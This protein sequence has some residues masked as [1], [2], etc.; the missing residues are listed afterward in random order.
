MAATSPEDLIAALEALKALQESQQEEL[1]RLSAENIELRDAVQPSVQLAALT[2]E[3]VNAVNVFA[4]A[5]QDMSSGDRRVKSLIDIKGLG[6]P[7]TFKNDEQRFIEWLRKTTGFASAAYGASFRGVLEWAEDQEQAI[8]IEDL[9]VQFG[10]EGSEDYVDDIAEKDSQLH[11]ALQALTEG[12]S[13]DIVLGATPHGV[14][15]LRRLIRRWDPA[16]GG[17]RRVILRQIVQPERAK[18]TELP[19]ALEKWDGLLRRYQKR[20]AGG[21]V[22]QPVDDDIKISALEG[23][24]PSEL[25]QHLAMNR[26]RL[27][28]YAQVR[29]E[30]DAYVDAKHSQGAISRRS[31]KKNE[32]AMDVDSFQKG[33]KGKGK[34]KG[35]GKK[36]GAVAGRGNQTEAT[37][38]NCGKPG[39]RQADCWSQ[40]QQQQPAAAKGKGKKGG[41]NKGKPANSLEEGRAAQGQPAPEPSAAGCL[42]ICSFSVV[43]AAELMSLEERNVDENGWLRFTFDTGAAITAFPSDMDVGE[44]T[45]Q[46]DATYRTASGEVIEDRGGLAV[47]GWSESGH[48]VRLSGRRAD[49]HKVLV[50]AGQVH[51]RGHITIL[52]KGGGY[53]IP[54][55]SDLAKKI[56]RLVSNEI[57]HVVGVLPIYE[58]KGTY[59]GYVQVSRPDSGDTGGRALCAVGSGNPRQERP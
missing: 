52:E 54:G 48:P 49:V 31:G 40:P 44:K 12:E 46:N 10:A 51:T 16:S 8:T 1:R 37:C 11:V 57:D 18:L 36:G 25:E 2:R 32:D 5:R 4:T 41:K 59:A 22:M 19:G 58:E 27:R 6:K 23:L 34:G 33:A 56:K 35:K 47:S 17:R 55:E 39:H 13:F 20:R 14:E 50:A 53:I 45:A 38:W 3:L 30:I 9:E 7:T 28:T 15:A 24:V 21:E 29:A 43:S 26:S 42:D